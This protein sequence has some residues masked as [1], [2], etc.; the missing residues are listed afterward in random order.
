MCVLVFQHK[1]LPIDCL[2]PTN[3]PHTRCVFFQCVHMSEGW[4]NPTE[5]SRPT[6]NKGA[7]CQ[8]QGR[9][10][11]L[12]RRWLVGVL[13]WGGVSSLEQTWMFPQF[14]QTLH[15]PA[16]F[17]SNARKESERAGEEDLR[18]GFRGC[19]GG[20]G[21]GAVSEEVS[22]KPGKGWGL[23][24]ASELIGTALLFYPPTKA[25]SFWK[26]YEPPASQLPQSPLTT[27]AERSHPHPSLPST[28]TDI[29]SHTSLSLTYSGN[30]P[31]FVS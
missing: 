11:R 4:V 7:F 6:V 10:W 23:L 14:P 18:V 15:F 26:A 8:A 28:L 3:F 17:H 24:L 27:A 25:C 31:V 1:K 9:L 5:V 19:Q 29:F 30:I 2:P 16:Y 13:G 21:G 12:G 22:G 20:G